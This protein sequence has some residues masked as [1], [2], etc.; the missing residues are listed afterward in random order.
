ME[1]VREYEGL[2]LEELEAQ[3]AELLPDRV[4]MGDFRLRIRDINNTNVSQQ[5]AC[6]FAF[7]QNR[8]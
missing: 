5:N 4:E 3:S 7:C 8:L 6:A 1:K 2:A